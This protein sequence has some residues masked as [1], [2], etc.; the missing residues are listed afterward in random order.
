[1]MPIGM[2]LLPGGCGKEPPTCVGDKLTA[3]AAWHGAVNPPPMKD[4]PFWWHRFRQTTT[5]FVKK[6]QGAGGNSSTC[7]AMQHVEHRTLQA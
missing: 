2:G 3:V 1:M 5:R 4:S 6:E 7:L